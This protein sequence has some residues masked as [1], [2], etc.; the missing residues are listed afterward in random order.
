MPS[1]ACSTALKWALILDA[2]AFS[3]VAV[4]VLKGLSCLLLIDTLTRES[5][6]TFQLS[7]ISPDNTSKS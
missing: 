7:I 3:V 1:S 6:T 4:A 5:H 2:L